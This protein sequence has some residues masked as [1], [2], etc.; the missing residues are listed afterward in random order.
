MYRSGPRS[1][2]VRLALEPLDARV[3]PSF[4]RPVNYLVNGGPRESV[5]ADFNGD[6]R[7]DV[8]VVQ[9]YAD[10]IDVFFGDGTGK[11]VPAKSYA[12]GGGTAP[13]GLVAV[14]LNRD[15]RPDL[16]TANHKSNNPGTVS[17]LLNKGDGTFGPATFFAAGP[18]PTK[19][20]VV[21]FNGDGRPDVA[22]TNQATSSGQATVSVLLGNGDGS[23]QPPVS[24]AAGLYPNSV[25]AGDLNGDGRPD[26]TV[27]NGVVNTVSVLLN[28][29]DGTFSPAGSYA[30]SH[31]PWGHSLGDV[32]GDGRLDLVVAN[33]ADTVSVLLGN[34]DGTF[35]P[36]VDF[37]TGGVVPLFPVIG[38]FNH[39]HR[40]DIAVAHA[41]AGN[42]MV[43]VEPVSVLLGNGDG[44][45]QPSQDFPVAPALG[46]AVGDLNSDRFPD[47]VVIDNI[48]A[49]G[50]IHVLL[51]DG[52]WTAPMPP[53]G[54]GPSAA[55]PDGLPADGGRCAIAS[56][57]QA[58]VTE[59]DAAVQRKPTSAV[60]ASLPRP[61]DNT[62]L[63]PE[64]LDL[65]QEPFAQ[66]TR[67]QPPSGWAT[68]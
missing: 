52:N 30:V 55:P 40:P 50:N 1:S 11:L 66:W 39:D 17:V 14:D 26:L 63:A 46:L 61:V 68:R 37:T 27:D 20:T 7:P 67:A 43:S 34:G 3:L 56:P 18:H 10:T 21:D 36:P 19:I 8:A 23:L 45:F 51:N 65:L 49:P 22:V 42:G 38:D 59:D 62:P 48:S 12:T 57:A 28:K 29:G 47:L 2:P 4:L 54:G 24:Y 64:A 15:G 35:R 13:F 58:Q 53:P 25:Q 5:I 60:V 33:G 9:T 6:G 16:V 31:S 32:N 44:T 41:Y